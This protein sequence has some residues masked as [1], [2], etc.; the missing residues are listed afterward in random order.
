V[1]SVGHGG[2]AVLAVQEEDFDCVLM[3]IQMPEVDGVEATQRIR[4]LIGSAG[5]SMPFVVALTAFA[6]PGDRERF[7]AA[8]M[9]GYL[10]KPVREE[11]LA[12]LLAG[13]PRTG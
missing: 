11:D 12:G 1:R 8:G 13:L 4:A 3:D 6:M 9:D 5:R 10:S 7:L 2:E